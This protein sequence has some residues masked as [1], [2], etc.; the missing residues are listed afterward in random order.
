MKVKLGQAVKTFFGNSS[1][2]MVFLEAIANSLDADS[3]KIEI[4]IKAKSYSESDSL[5]VTIDDNGIGFTDERYIKFSNLLDVEETSHKGLG[6]LV[7]LCYFNDVKINSYYN[8]TYNRKIDFTEN[9]QENDNNVTRV[10]SRHSGT[11][12]Q[13][14]GYTLSRLKQ[15]SFINPDY[16]KKRVLEEFYPKL[17]LSQQESKQI[18]ITIKAIIESNEYIAS[19]NNYELPKLEKIELDSSIS[20]IDKFYLHYSIIKVEE[21]QT[22]F[23][24]AITVDNRTK[25]VEIISEENI[26]QGYDMVFLLYS[27]WF[28]GKIDS[29]R[30]N[31]TISETELQTIQT[32]FRKKVAEIIEQKIPQV[33]ER[34]KRTYNNLIDRFP[35]LAGYF[36]KDT[37][38]Y[39]SK[40]DALKKAQDKFFKAQKD[41]LE[42]STL[43]DAQYEKSLELSARALTE[44]ILFRQV[45]IDNLK[46]STKKDSEAEL[47]NMFATMKTQFNKNNLTEDLYRNNAWLLDDKYMTYETVLSDKEM[48]ELIKY[49]TDEDI[50]DDDR[51]DIA[52]VF[53]NNPNIV[54]AFDVVI[55]EIKKRGISLEENMKTVTQLEK[56]ARKLM[57]Y[58]E[59]KIQRIWY[60]GIIEMNDEVELALTGEYK[61]LYSSGKAYYRETKVA[62]QKNPEIIL[63]IGVF[64]WDIDAV[65]NDANARNSAF[66]NLIKSKFL[67]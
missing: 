33:Q 63:P 15:Y 18:T 19:L 51:P 36:N 56:R 30:Q 12:I 24:A 25:K 55:V 3:T 32:L 50:K 66:L 17:F 2:E 39:V 52:L 26:P 1:L 45:T 5:E 34:N 42:A 14:K 43:S 13:M 8:E 6:R 59:N 53:S 16:L 49:I 37:V 9:F 38:G 4:N 46:R 60:Y 7:Y 29:S 54:S 48:G 21:I 23:V 44:Y 61:E 31:L 65:V 27:D 58:Y 35:H 10:S 62:I 20:V 41:L 28:T 22:S 57:Q 67:I 64:I 47:H 11:T 40:S